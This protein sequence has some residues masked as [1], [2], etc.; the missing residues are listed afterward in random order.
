MAKYKQE[1]PIMFRIPKVKKDLQKAF[2]KAK[3]KKGATAVIIPALEKY[4][5]GE[6]DN[7]AFIVKY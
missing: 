1:A 7:G 5:L 6:D 2:D 3:K 4:L